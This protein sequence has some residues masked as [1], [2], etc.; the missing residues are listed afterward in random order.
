MRPL[1]PLLAAASLAGCALGPNYRRP[2]LTLPEQWKHGSVEWKQAEPG[3]GQERGPWWEVF[4]DQ[5]LDLLEI[6]AVQANQDLQAAMARVHEARAIARITRSELLPNVTADGSYE[7]FRRSLS[8]I[9]SGR[10]ILNQTYDATLDLSY[11]IDFWGRVRRAFESARADAEASEAAY[12]TALLGLTAEVAQNHF[13]LRA[14]DSELEI[15]DHTVALRREALDLA[16]K[17]LE[18][19]IAGEL[20]AARARTELSAAEAEAIDVGR[21]RAELENALAVLCGRAASEFRI[22]PIPLDTPLPGIPPGLPSALL[23]R[24]PDVAE[25]ERRVA[26]ANAQIGIA[27]AAFFPKITFSASGGFSNPR[28]EDLFTL[29]SRVWSIGPAVSIPLTAIG[30]NAA[31]VRAVKARH[32][33][34]TAQYRQR[35]LTAIRETED[36]LANLRFREAEAGAQDRVVEAAQKAAS[37]A[38][39]RYREG[40]VNYLEV[41]DAERSRLAAERTAVQIRSRRLISTVLLVRA[42]GGGWQHIEE[43]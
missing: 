28:V 38:D 34:T 11:E 37:L 35:V 31:N 33:E 41:I 36:A 8:G 26:S 30:R 16:E 24:R 17:R 22:E 27:Q 12:Q 6:Q 4:G 15:L 1:I 42:L 19:G 43:P 23:E 39:A 5:H 25:A 18:S 40:L 13:A 29:D 14:L 21:R 3:D 32:E 7:R 20:D 2:E 9:G 10:S